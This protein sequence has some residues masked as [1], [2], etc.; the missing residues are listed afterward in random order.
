MQRP[1]AY[2]NNVAAEKDADTSRNSDIMNFANLYIVAELT[3]E[4]LKYPVR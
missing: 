2:C 1:Q 4:P 3:I